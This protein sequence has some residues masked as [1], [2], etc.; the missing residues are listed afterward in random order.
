MRP[1]YYTPFVSTTILKHIRLKL[2]DSKSVS[3]DRQKVMLY[4]H[5]ARCYNV[6]HV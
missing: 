2:L 5:L 4:N 1:L 6:N 3:S